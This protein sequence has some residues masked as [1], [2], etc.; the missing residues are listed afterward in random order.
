MK[1]C[2][3][4]FNSNRVRL[5][6]S[7]YAWRDEGLWF[8]SFTSRS[9]KPA[10]ADLKASLSEACCCR[11]AAAAASVGLGARAATAAAAEAE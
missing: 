5:G 11:M 2:N 7:A 1:L 9:V 6:G 10:S 3:Y 8:S 4:F